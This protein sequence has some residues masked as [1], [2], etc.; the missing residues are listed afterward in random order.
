MRLENHIALHSE[1]WPPGEERWL[2]PLKRGDEEELFAIVDRNREYLRQF[3]TWPRDDHEIEDYRDVINQVETEL[4]SGSPNHRYAIREPERI[5]GHIALLRVQHEPPEIGFWLDE[6]DT[7]KGIMQTAARTLTDLAHQQ[8]QIPIVAMEIRED[9][10]ASQQVA[11]RV[12]YERVQEGV[13]K[14][15]PPVPYGI[16]HSHQ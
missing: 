3:L 10:I 16:W 11:R 13:L 5:I 2:E 4:E 7:G 15:G 12:G 9:N 8:L 14:E 1:R 6:V